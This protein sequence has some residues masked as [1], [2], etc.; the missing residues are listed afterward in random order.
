MMISDE[1]VAAALLQYLY[2]LPTLLAAL[3]E[4]K[5]G[6][7]EYDWQGENFKYP[8]VRF[9][10]GTQSPQ[11]D[12]TDCSIYR[13]NF[14]LIV[15]SEQKS[16]KEANQIMGIINAIIHKTNF[17]SGMVRFAYIHIDSLIPAMRKDVMTWQ[18]ETRYHTIIHKTTDTY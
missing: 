16:S 12:E 7:H 18:A 9:K 5:S 3:P 1:L 13:Q 11:P 17:D 4:G 15:Y 8:C 10:L 6:I 2:S 14:S